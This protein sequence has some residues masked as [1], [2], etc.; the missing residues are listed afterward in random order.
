MARYMEYLG[1]P[2]FTYIVVYSLA[3]FSV[4]ALL[5]G[6]HRTYKGVGLPVIV[7]QSLTRLDKVFSFL[8]EFLTHYSS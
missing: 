3:V 5:Y 2:E 1:V 8:V 7:R 4:A 6:L